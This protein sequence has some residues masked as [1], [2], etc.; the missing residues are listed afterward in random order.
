[1]LNYYLNTR[2]NDRNDIFDDFFKLPFEHTFS[3]LPTDIIE[4]ENEYVLEVQAPGYNKEDIKLS[5]DDGYLTIEVSKNEK[6]EDK[7]GKYVRKE[8][9]YGSSSRSYYVGNVDQNL[10]KANFNNGILEV[11]VPKDEMPVVDNTKYISID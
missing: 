5:L 11:S 4:K 7:G 3:N 10:I 8:I 6:K 2:K 1:M 9:F